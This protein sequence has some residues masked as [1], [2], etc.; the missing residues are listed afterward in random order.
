MC[1][2]DNPQ[3]VYS[4]QCLQA[5]VG[6][7]DQNASTAGPPSKPEEHHR[8]NT[9]FTSVDKVLAAIE[10][11]LSRNDPREMNYGRFAPSPFGPKSFRPNSKSF[12]PNSKSFRPNLKSFRPNYLKSF[13]PDYK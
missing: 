11:R 12:R 9:F 2:D 13:C 7:T 1:H 5:L 6:D 4:L 8:V 3:H 10:N